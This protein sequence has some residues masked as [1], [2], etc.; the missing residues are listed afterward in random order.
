[1]NSILKRYRIFILSSFQKLTEF[2]KNT[3]LEICFD[4]CGIAKA[5]FLE[6]DALFL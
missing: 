6:E 3:S 1:M 4:A 5:D 2:I